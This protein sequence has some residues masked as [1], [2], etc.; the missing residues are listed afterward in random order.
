[1]YTTTKYTKEAMLPHSS[2]WTLNEYIMIA[3]QCTSDNL[4]PRISAIQYA[5]RVPTLAMA[6]QI[7]NILENNAK[8]VA[9]VTACR[10]TPRWVTKTRVGLPNHAMAEIY[11]K[12]LELVGPTVYDESAKKVAREIQKSLGMEPMEEP[13]A[14]G[15]QKL[16]TLQDY[17]A[18]ERRN[19][20]PWQMHYAADDYTDYTW[21]APTV[22]AFTAKAVL[23]TAGPDMTYGT[24]IGTGT[25][26]T[27]K[28][29]KSY[30]AWA[31]NAMS[32]IRSTIDP[33]IFVAGRALGCTYIDLLST[34]EEL[35]RAQAEFKQRTGGG[36]G[37]TKW[38]PPLLPTD[39]QPCIDLRWPEYVTTVRGEE[40]WIPTPKPKT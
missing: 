4:P 3:G 39:F 11:Y 37:G 13:L 26:A 38:V 7:Y 12:N 31:Q 8:H 40:W 19:L 5:W 6:Q 35:G 23:K 18:S 36:I 20:E 22:R 30:P 15:C 24:Q 2:Y 29:G 9:E 21:H 10:V 27:D 14:E 16:T 25:E 33:S 34:P 1:M 17:E 32:G 28:G